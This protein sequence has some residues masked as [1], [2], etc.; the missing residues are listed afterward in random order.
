MVVTFLFNFYIYQS[1]TF[2]NNL[3]DGEMITF[4]L[5]CYIIKQLLHYKNILNMLYNKE[6]VAQTCFVKKMFLEISKNSQEN[7]CARVTFL[8]KLQVAPAQ[9]P[10][11][12]F[13][14][15]FCE[16]SHNTRNFSRTLW[17]AASA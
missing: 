12:M 17:T 10:A 5:M 16:I 8:I 15:E 7:I 9:I 1:H 13:S 11:Q 14:C 4:H 3:N 6:V 2:I